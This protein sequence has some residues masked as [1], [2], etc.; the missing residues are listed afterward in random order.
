MRGISTCGAVVSFVPAVYISTCYIVRRFLANLHHP[1]SPCLRTTWRRRGPLPTR[2][3]YVPTRLDIRGG[4]DLSPQL[5][6]ENIFNSLIAFA[7]HPKAQ[8]CNSYPLVTEVFNMFH[9]NGV[10]GSTRGSLAVFLAA[11]QPAFG[12]R[13][14]PDLAAYLTQPDVEDGGPLQSRRGPRPPGEL[15]PWWEV[16]KFVKFL[17]DYVG[18]G[19]LYLLCMPQLVRYPQQ[20]FID[21]PSRREFYSFFSA[22]LGFTLLLWPNHEHTRFA[23]SRYKFTWLKK[24]VE[25]L[26]AAFKMQLNDWKGSHLADHRRAT[27]NSVAF[28]DI[29]KRCLAEITVKFLL[30]VSPIPIYWRQNMFVGRGQE[31]ALS[32]QFRKALLVAHSLPDLGVKSRDCPDFDVPPDATTY[33]PTPGTMVRTNELVTHACSSSDSTHLA[34]G[35]MSLYRQS[36]IRGIHG[37]LGRRVRKHQAC[38]WRFC[39]FEQQQLQRQEAVWG[40]LSA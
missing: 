4:A 35:S 33:K 1:L 30:E 9:R 21:F 38:R 25:T 5:T 3:R 26:K 16:K 12:D 28:R 27:G 15:G 22:G 17:E 14:I 31:R 36:N 8:E 37:K 6:T 34:G 13:S 29:E 32:P 19:E 23:A 18:Y 20:A 24:V 2:L 40:C 39:G 11:P 7:A 10:E